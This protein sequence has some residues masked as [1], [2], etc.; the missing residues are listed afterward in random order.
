LSG[1]IKAYKPPHEPFPVQLDDKHK[2]ILFG[3]VCGDCGSSW[4][5]QSV[6]YLQNSV[7]EK[8]AAVPKTLAKHGQHPLEKLRSSRSMSNLFGEPAPKAPSIN[9]NKSTL[10]LRALSEEMEK[11]HGKQANSVMVKFSGIECTCGCILDSSAL[12]FQI[13][14]QPVREVVEAPA[15]VSKQATFSA[16]PEDKAQGI[17]TPTITLH[18]RGVRIRHANPLRSAPVTEEEVARLYG[19]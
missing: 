10:N 16:T 8:I 3:V 13:I 11:E 14:D 7:R 17:E 4:Q 5:A 6:G 2:R 12:C 19:N 9:V 18:P 15:V 1:N